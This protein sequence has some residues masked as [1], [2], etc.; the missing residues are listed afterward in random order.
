MRE[1]KRGRRRYRRGT[2]GMHIDETSKSKKRRESGDM[3]R[4]ERGGE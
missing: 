2:R 3:S 1:S 4:Q